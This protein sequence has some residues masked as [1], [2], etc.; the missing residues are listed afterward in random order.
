M[1]HLLQAVKVLGV[2]VWN[3]LLL[4]VKCS[5]I[6]MWLL[7]KSRLG[8][9]FSCHPKITNVVSVDM[10]I[11][12]RIFTKNAHYITARG[13]VRSLTL[14]LMT[15]WRGTEMYGGIWFEVELSGQVTLLLCIPLWNC[16]FQTCSSIYQATF[17]QVKLSFVFLDRAESLPCL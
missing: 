13:R 6:I 10:G 11:E 5:I 15:Q 7:M 12:I 1:C 3:C 4:K 16:L 14:K 17:R 2:T 9:V 8:S